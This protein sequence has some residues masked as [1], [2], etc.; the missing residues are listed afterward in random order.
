MKRRV[1]FVLAFGLAVAFVGAAAAGESVLIQKADVVVEAVLVSY[2]QSAG[3][4]AYQGPAVQAGEDNWKPAHRYTGVEIR[5]LLAAVGGMG[6]ADVLT[7]VAADGYQKAIPYDVLYGETPV[8]RVSLAVTRDGSEPGAWQDAPELVFL[9]QDERFSNDDMLKAFGEARAHFY[10]PGQPSTTGFLMK[11]VACLIVNYAGGALPTKPTQGA[12]PPAAGVSLEVV[13]GGM[14][15]IYTLAALEMLDTI[16]APGTFTT[17]AGTDYSATYTGVPLST[18][19]GNVP[20]DATV[21]VT[22]SDGYSMN[23]EAGMLLGRT[24][25]TWVL[26]YKENEA[27]MPFDPGPLRVV[28]VGEA[29][30]HFQSSLSAKM[31]ER[32]EV[33]GTY[34]PYS[35]V[36]K[37][38][39]TRTFTRAELEAGIGCP[40]HAATVTVKS[41]GETHTY[42]GLPLWRLVAYVD[43]N[44]FPAPEQGI[45]YE[46]G[47]FNDA[48]ARAGYT[49]TLVASDGYTQSVSSSLIGRDDRFVVAFKRDGVFVDAS[50]DGYM[51]F[52]YDDSVVLPEGA[53]LKSVKLLAEIDLGL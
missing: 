13:K 43:D 52:V 35:L 50:K 8:G 22:A 6:P 16:T 17:S 25:G 49:I 47:D 14:E 18:L 48:L 34:E 24:E 10:A 19:I 45:H 21:R 38:V 29:N 53:T 23:Y 31:V 39:V 3:T 9:P 40:C 32:I 12:T 44:R 46:D 41:K 15:S 2:P 4:V 1:E 30:P 51:R 26:A 11:N 27:Y 7:V 33:L 20:V 37:G 36:L 28:F 5:E 42:T